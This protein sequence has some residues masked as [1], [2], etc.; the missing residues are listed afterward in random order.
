M[1]EPKSDYSSIPPPP[2]GVRWNK[3]FKRIWRRI[4]GFKEIRVELWDLWFKS[5]EDAE[6]VRKRCFRSSRDLCFKKISPA[7]PIPSH[8]V[9]YSEDGVMDLSDSFHSG[10]I[11]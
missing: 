9:S 1:T 5:P 7:A 8:T 10:F 6:R 3:G 2:G 11:F 4:K